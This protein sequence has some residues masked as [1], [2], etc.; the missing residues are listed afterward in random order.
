MKQAKDR[1]LGTI[2]NPSLAGLKNTKTTLRAFPINLHNLSFRFS[3]ES[4]PQSAVLGVKT[5]AAVGFSGRDLCSPSNSLRLAAAIFK[6]VFGRPS[7]RTLH[8]RDPPGHVKLFNQPIRKRS[9]HFQG[10]GCS[11]FRR[12]P[13]VRRKR[14]ESSGATPNLA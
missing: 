1:T 4:Q 5:P 10:N 11:H 8:R 6:L 7:D 12:Q 2:Q 9:L 14:F 13:L 3:I